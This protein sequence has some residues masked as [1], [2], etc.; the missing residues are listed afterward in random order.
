[1]PPLPLVV[2]LALY[3][4]TQV[5]MRPLPALSLAYFG[6]IA[7]GKIAGPEGSVGAAVGA[8]LASFGAAGAGAG[9]GAGAA[10]GAAAGVASAA[11]W[12]LRKSFHFWPF[13]VPAS[14]AVLYFA[15]H[16]CM[17]SACAGAVTANAAKLAPAIAHNNLA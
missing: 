8:A 14:F 11:H 2:L 3:W 4:S 12:A 5:C 6:S 7:F 17:V 9:A 1:M 16:S 10:A 13:S 15:L